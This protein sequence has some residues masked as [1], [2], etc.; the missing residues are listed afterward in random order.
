MW[1]SIINTSYPCTIYHNAVQHVNIKQDWRYIDVK[2][3][4]E[5]RLID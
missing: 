5:H 4:P 1:S 3:K 2:S